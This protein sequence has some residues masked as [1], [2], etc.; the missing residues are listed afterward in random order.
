[1]GAQV[2]FQL[3]QR[4]GFQQGIHFLH[5]RRLPHDDALGGAHVEAAQQRG[6]LQGRVLLLQL[7]GRH[8]VV[9]GQR[10][11]QVF[12]AA[13]GAGQ[14]GFEAHHGFH[15][16]F[17]RGRLFAEQLKGVGEV[18][19]VGGAHALRTGVIL[20]IIVP[21][22]HAQPALIEVGGVLGA[23][24]GVGVHAH[25]HE[26]VG[27]QLLLPGQ[28]RRQRGRGFHRHDAVQLPLQRRQP[29]PV[30][31]RRVHGRGVVV[32]HFLQIRTLGRAFG[33]GRL[34]QNPAHD[35]RVA[36]V[37]NAEVA[38]VGFGRRN[39]RVLYPLAIHV[40]REIGAG[41][42]GRVEVGDVEADAGHDGR[43]GGGC[44]GRRRS[45]R[46]ARRG[47]GGG[48][49]GGAAGGTAGQSEASGGGQ[50]TPERGGVGHIKSGLDT[51]FGGEK[52]RQNAGMMLTPRLGRPPRAPH[53]PA[54]SPKRRGGATA[55]RPIS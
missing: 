30:D 8:F 29:R 16:G 51:V 33:G 27:A 9:V 15:A 25:L 47:G 1:M 50:G 10:V 44:R 6:H 22:A 14:P 36:L 20:Q 19:A 28:H 13:R 31:G 5:K 54:P 48:L 32:A 11:A 12:L 24:L 38:P 52:I 45:S 39:R 34:V 7:G 26:G 43:G 37:E 21:V 46:G 53:P 4:R 18:A 2:G 41:R 55:A 23:V 42:D 49:R 3:R 35:D 17:R 40:L